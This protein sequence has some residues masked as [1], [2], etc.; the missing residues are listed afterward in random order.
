MNQIFIN[1]LNRIV[2][3]EHVMDALEDRT[4][5]SYDASIREGLPDIVV[6]PGDVSEIA[7]I[8]RLART[9]NIPV[10]PR[11]AAS[12]VTAGA[13]PLK[14]G[15]SLG[16]TRLNRIIEIDTVNKVAVVE[17]GVITQDLINAVD[18]AGLLYPPDPASSKVS[19]MGGN[20]AECAGGPK[21][22]KYGI[23]RDY[24]LALEVVLPDG[25]VVTVGNPIDGDMS[26][27]DWTM[28]FVGS[29]GTVGIVTK[30][31]V[32]LV[33]KPA[34]KQTVLAIFDRLDDAATT[35][36]T[37]IASGII[38]TTLELMDNT[39]IRA[40]EDY[41]NAGL[42]I[43]ADAILLIEVDGSEAS[44]QKQSSKVIYVCNACGASRTEIAK[45][46]DEINK[47]W[48][49]RR[50]INPACGRIAPT[51]ISEDA[52]VPRSEIPAMVRSVKEIAEKHNLK[53]IIFGH[54][55]DGNLHPNFLTNKHNKEEMERVEAAIHDLFRVALNL[56]GTLSGEHG[57]GSVKAPFLKWEIGE[58]G[59]EAGKKVKNA[60]DPQGILNPGKLFDYNFS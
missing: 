3:R 43:D 23:T 30:I 47:L 51:K 54:A 39:T 26:G 46:A 55:G 44:V 38:P 19:T 33:D 37:I 29:E 35:V 56:G 59:F 32:K 9:Y 15:I 31:F 48:H 5:Y 60:F 34:T 13:V 45:T 28:L 2:G 16:V 25:Q 18:N 49:A 7:E 12:G 42:P 8:M 53:I 4:C 14:G 27:P 21:G 24:V 22:V 41:L 40:V 17:P 58:V 57:I 36:S 52:T 20:I 50:S 6:K 11:G 1:E 10:T